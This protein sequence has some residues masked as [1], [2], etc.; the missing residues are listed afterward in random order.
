[1]R[2]SHYL[3]IIATI[4]WMAVAIVW[5]VDRFI[6]DLSFAPIEITFLCAFAV[7]A[8]IGGLVFSEAGSLA[9]QLE[10]GQLQFL[11]P[12]ALM[13]RLRFAARR[14]QERREE[15]AEMRSAR[16]RGAHLRRW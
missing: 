1:M 15:A 6:L 5:G 4:A 13:E 16:K 14:R 2:L 7:S 8:L 12:K 3:L 10:F 11:T 9:A